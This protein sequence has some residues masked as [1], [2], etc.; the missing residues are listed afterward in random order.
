MLDDLYDERQTQIMINRKLDELQPKYEQQ[1]DKAQQDF[2]NNVEEMKNYV[3]HCLEAAERVATREFEK[4]DRIC[5][6]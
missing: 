5:L 6:I 2:S 3:G 4:K 1:S